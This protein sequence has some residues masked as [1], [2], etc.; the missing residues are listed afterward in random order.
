MPIKKSVF[1][2]IAVGSIFIIMI[3]LLNI[4]TVY[5][6]PSGTQNTTDTNTI[7]YRGVNMRGNYT[8]QTQY[9]DPSALIFPDDYYNQ[10]FRMIS[11]SGMNLVRYLFFWEAYEK[12]P[13]QFRDELE[14]VSKFADKWKVNVIYANDNY[15]T[16]SYLDPKEGYGFPSYLFSND[17][18]I[19]GSGGGYRPHNKDAKLWWSKLW[20]RSLTSINGTDAWNLQTNFLKNIVA[21]VD[22][23]NSTLGY[24]ILNEP[25]VYSSNQWEN[26]GN[27]NTFIVDEMRTKTSKLIFYD[28]QVPSEIY[29][30]LDSSSQNL[31]KMAPSNKTNIVFKTTVYSVPTGGSYA[32]NRLHTSAQAAK[33]AGV[34]LC[35]CEFGLYPKSRDSIGEPKIVLSEEKI[36]E[37][38][39]K[40]QELN[41]WGWAIWIWDYKPRDN[42][43][44]NLVNFT[45]GVGTATENLYH[46]INAISSEKTMPNQ[47]NDTIFPVA[48]LTSVKI[49]KDGNGPVNSN[50][51]D[52]ESQEKLMVKG[53]AFDVGSGI[54]NVKVRIND[55]PFSLANQ[56]IPGDWLNWY[57]TF[58]I[59]PNDNNTL[60]VKSEDNAKNEE[61]MTLPGEIESLLK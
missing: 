12:N 7:D 14:Q 28:R 31:A 39:Q 19:N 34:P 35:L 33:L 49:L 29:G 21:A 55:Q 32:E 60:I 17:T 57:A 10:S 9:R 54:N 18:F 37:F 50:S 30:N 24:E 42:N 44:F 2:F 5:S 8:S 46:I 40:L 59:N 58:S 48:N 61:Y 47:I 15:A 51:N 16:S 3:S 26:I 45:N 13:K 38:V 11:E 6:S 22:K 56:T 25:H 4:N 53:E 23:H 1:T 27:Y 20:D 36:A 43:N 52:T 41:A